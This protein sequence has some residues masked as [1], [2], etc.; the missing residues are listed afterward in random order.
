MFVKYCKGIN[1]NNISYLNHFINLEI[2]SMNHSYYVLSI[3]NQPTHNIPHMSKLSQI[4]WEKWLEN[5]FEKRYSFMTFFYIEFT[6][7]P[8]GY[9]GG[10]QFTL[11]LPD[12]KVEDIGQ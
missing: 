2:L 12:S 1:F 5:K 4:R 11:L 8:V 9:L 3:I 6:T 7:L 10:F